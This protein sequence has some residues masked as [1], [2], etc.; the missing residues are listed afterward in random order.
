MFWILLSASGVLVVPTPLSDPDTA[1]LDNGTIRVGR[2]RSAGG[3]LCWVSESGGPNL[4]NV[5]DLGRGC[6][7]ALFDTNA[8]NPT[9]AGDG[10]NAAPCELFFADDVVIF[11]KSVPLLFYNTAKTG[12]PRPVGDQRFYMWTEI[13]P[14]TGGRAFLAR[15][16]WANWN[17][18]QGVC[19]Q[20]QME[21]CSYLNPAQRLRV[22]SYLGNKPWT[23]GILSTIV[24]TRSPSEEVDF[25]MT[26][27]WSAAIDAKGRGLAC[28][29]T[30]SRGKSRNYRASGGSGDS[31]N[32]C[33]TNDHLRR[34]R[35]ALNAGESLQLREGWKLFYVG[36]VSEAR[37]L[38][39][40]C[41]PVAGGP[42]SDDFSEHGLLGWDANTT[43]AAATGNTVSIGPYAGA[44][45][46]LSLAGKVW[47]D[48]TYQVEILLGGGGA[49]GLAFRKVGEGHYSDEATGYYLATLDPSGLLSL[50]NSDAGLLASEAVPGFTPSGWHTL[51]VS[52]S[53]FDF[54]VAVDGVEYLDATDKARSFPAGYLSLVCNAGATASFR[55]LQVTAGGDSSP[56]APVTGFTAAP[57][58]PSPRVLISWINPGDPDWLWTRIVRKEGGSPSHWR[59]GF[60]CYEGKLSGYTDVDVTGGTE[61]VYAAFAVDRA[62]NWS[63]PAFAPVTP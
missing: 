30:D 29:S 5:H 14:G 49:A 34:F 7:A 4:V 37:D 8:W 44:P 31:L 58:S 23:G 42:F 54:S 36:A 39:S 40:A 55:N 62:G 51:A 24:T 6:Q 38:F 27:N 21:P 33:L 15:T 53:G 48:A 17:S 60:P 61:Y 16:A 2:Q 12:P 46:D 10:V 19:Q 52:S 47:G 41:A 18:R 25:R 22:V 13:L 50:C 63:S 11:S 45:N 28:L 56:T 35:I 57:G 32:A 3:W 20:Q 9:Q 43:P 1:F 59:D 26:E